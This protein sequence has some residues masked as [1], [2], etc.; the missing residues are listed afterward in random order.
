MLLMQSDRELAVIE[1]AL[2]EV[3]DRLLGPLS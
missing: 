1:T 3:L 2:A